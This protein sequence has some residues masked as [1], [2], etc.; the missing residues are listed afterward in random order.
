MTRHIHAAL[1]KQWAD[2]AKIQ[3]YYKKD[4]KWVDVNPSWYPDAQYRVKP[5]VFTT[6]PYRR[7][8]MTC[9]DGTAVVVLA[10]DKEY[11]SHLEKEQNYF[12]KWV[13]D[14]WVTHSVEI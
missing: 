1:I 6:K 3:V 11:A 4:D 13:D 8:I 9:S 10:H 5:Q 2:G 12:V 7:C 14:D